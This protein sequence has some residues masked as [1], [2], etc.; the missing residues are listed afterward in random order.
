MNCAYVTFVMRN[1]SFIPGALVLAYQIKEQSDFD[2]ICLVTSDVTH[3]GREQLS[4]LFDQVI[5]VEEIVVPHKNR[6]SRQDRPFLFTR[7]QALNINE[8]Q[9]KHYDKIAV[10]DA[11][12]LPLK[13]YDDLFELPTPAGIINEKKEYCVRYE[14][15]RYIDTSTDDGQ[16]HWHK[17]YHHVPHGTLIPQAITDHVIMDSDNLGVNAGILV[18]NPSKESFESLMTS[19]KMESSMK[20]IETLKW[21]EQQFFTKYYSGYWS[22]IDLR[23]ASFNGYPN[24][25]ILYGT[26]FAGL[27]PWKVNHRSIKTFSRFDDFQLWYKTFIRMIDEN[28]KLLGFNSIKKVYKFASEHLV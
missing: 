7:F 13:K 14:N 28:H 17:H 16:W 22:N 11:D 24:L 2:I 5:V 15:G 9:E 19:I 1:D 3:S 25:N 21:P 23:Y 12:I 6:H 18:L 20:F 10:L 26:H 4:L 8:Y 27:K